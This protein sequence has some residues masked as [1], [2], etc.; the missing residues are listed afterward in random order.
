ME[1]FFNEFQELV[2]DETLHSGKLIVVGDFNLHMD[3]PYDPQIS[4]FL[5]IL[6]ASNLQQLV[7]EPTHIKGHI[8]D[9]VI[10]SVFDNSIHSVEVDQNSPSDHHWV[11]FSLSV[12]K[13][14]PVT[15]IIMSRNT[16]NIDM[17]LI[18]EEI[19]LSTLTDKVDSAK[20][21]QEKIEAFNTTLTG[22]LDKHA[23]LRKRRICL[24][25]NTQWY[26]DDIRLSKHERRLAE[27]KWRTTKLEVHRQ[28]YIKARSK[29]NQL[30]RESKVKHAQNKIIDNRSNSNHTETRRRWQRISLITSTTKLKRS[31]TGLV[32][33]QLKQRWQI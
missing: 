15:Q 3:K 27:K 20:T 29:T 9:L 13:P 7:E 10:N 17:N 14:K 23:P 22:I 16:K 1:Q 4:K 8:I 24:R 31:E 18:K 5:E 2:L 33:L 32:K 21:V 25:P 6:K 28:T 19:I 30:I 11:L 26:N 12:S